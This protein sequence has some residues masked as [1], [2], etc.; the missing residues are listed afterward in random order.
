MPPPVD[1]DDTT[2]ASDDQDTLHDAFQERFDT[3]VETPPEGVR[4]KFD[5]EDQCMKLKTV[6]RTLPRSLRPS[7]QGPVTDSSS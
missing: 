7:V 6:S 4:A 3:D 1:T 2:S 5:P